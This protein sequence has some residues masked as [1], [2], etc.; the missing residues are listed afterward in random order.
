MATGC[1]SLEKEKEEQRFD[2]VGSSND[3]GENW[4]AN[5]DGIESMEEHVSNGSEKALVLNVDAQIMQIGRQ[6]DISFGSMDVL[7]CNNKAN[8]GD[9]CGPVLRE[10]W[11]PTG[12]LSVGRSR[13]GFPDCKCDHLVQLLV[14][15]NEHTRETLDITDKYEI[16]VTVTYDETNG[17]RGS[18]LQMPDYQ[19]KRLRTETK[20]GVN[21]SMA[22]VVGFLFRFHEPS[23]KYKIVF[24]LQTA[25]PKKRGRKKI[26]KEHRV[27]EKLSEITVTLETG[28]RQLKKPGKPRKEMTARKIPLSSELGPA[29]LSKT[30]MEL[31]KRS[32]WVVNQL[33]SHRNDAKWDDFD[34]FSRDLLL[35]FKDTDTQITIKLEQSVAALYRKDFERSLELLDESFRLM[36][37]AKNMH[38]LAGRGY[39]YRAGVARRLKNL[40]DA[41]HFMQLAEQ[42]NRTCHTNLD[43]S[44]IAYEKASVLLDF[45]GL[46]PQRSLKQVS[47]ALHNLEKCIDVCLRVEMED[48]DLC[49]QRH[50]FAFVKIALLLLDCRTDSAR[51]RVLGKDLIAKGQDCLNTIKTKYWSEITEGLKIQFYLANSDL[52][53]RKENFMETVKFA[54]FAKDKA[55]E[56]GFKTEISLAQERLDHSRVLAR[57]NATGNGSWSTPATPFSASEG[58][59]GDISSSG[60]ESDWLKILE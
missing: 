7:T 12:K 1:N 15:K 40:G 54:S 2:F 55:E 41:D 20:C 58:E 26:S 39:G 45:I 57:G 32:T 11:I 28:F 47:E 6:S 42:N 35:R 59:K 23:T 16:V 33:Q 44:Y 46:S 17:T 18:S 38:L 14:C 34:K 48:N 56:S 13:S 4:E 31:C 29:S 10:H 53:Y 24:T 49:V 52:E 21:R 51:E 19:C 37:Q 50:H 43:T 36:P 60:S 9:E 22:G 27:C 25:P 3:Q 30:N 8:D 5:I